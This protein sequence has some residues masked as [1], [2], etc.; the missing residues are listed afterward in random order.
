[1]TPTDSFYA[2]IERENSLF[3]DRRADISGRLAAGTLTVRQ[4]AEQWIT[5]AEQH[6][7]TLRLL[8]EMHDGSD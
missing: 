6:L 4:A 3:D 1:M 5:L 2:Q 8:R 7:A